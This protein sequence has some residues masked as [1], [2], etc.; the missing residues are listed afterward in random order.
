M[1]SSSHL[2]CSVWTLQDRDELF[3]KLTALDL[4]NVQPED[5]LYH[6]QMK[7]LEGRMT[8]FEYLMNLN[9]M[10]GRSFNDLMQYPVFPF[11]LSQYTESTL[12]LERPSS[13]RFNLFLLI[14]QCRL[15]CLPKPFDSLPSTSSSLMCPLLWLKCPSRR[16]YISVTCY[17]PVYSVGL[18]VAHSLMTRDWTFLSESWYMWNAE[19]Q[20]QAAEGRRW[21]SCCAWHKALNIK[22]I[23]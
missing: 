17:N 16:W 13:Y 11:I 6:T 18:D 4:P 12:D 1:S 7:W 8:N 3:A 19:V 10:A 20:V 23:I 21:F 5:N 14:N 2:Y 22:E 9:K 15:N